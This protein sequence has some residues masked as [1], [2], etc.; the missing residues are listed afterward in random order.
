M[1]HFGC[2][3][4]VG[5]ELFMLRTIHLD[6]QF[7]CVLILLK[8]GVCLSTNFYSHFQIAEFVLYSWYISIIGHCN[9]SK[10]T[11]TEFVFQEKYCYMCVNVTVPIP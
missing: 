7:F 3:T 8:K 10:W 6:K 11:G 9:T 5:T 2:T 4:F 1:L